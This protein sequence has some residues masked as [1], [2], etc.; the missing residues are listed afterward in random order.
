[1]TL[2]LEW[3]DEKAASNLTKHRVAF[4]DAARVFL[5]PNRLDRHDGREN[6]GEDRFLMIGLVGMLELT[7]VYTVR[8][9]IFRIIS[10]RKAESNERHEYWKNRQ[11]YP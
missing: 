8:S 6:Y 3:D 1:M 2:S 11:V 10:A 5:D 4:E 9:D 7:V